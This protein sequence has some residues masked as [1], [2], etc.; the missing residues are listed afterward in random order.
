MHDPF[1]MRPFFGYNFGDYLQHWLS[2]GQHHDDKLRLPKIFHVNWFRKDADG[3][4]L[5]PG[6]GENCRVLDW[7]LRRCAGED[8][9]VECAVGLI[10][11]LD[12]LDLDGL[13]VTVPLEELFHLPRQFWENEV[14]AL[15]KYFDEQVNEDLPEEIMSELK[16]LENRVNSLP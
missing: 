14:N 9:A 1:A 5:W 3:R 10:P 11:K 2:F 13:K 7:I 15:Y 8:A 6:F 16:G 12:S 4:Y